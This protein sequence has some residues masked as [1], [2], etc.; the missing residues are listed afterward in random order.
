MEKETIELLKKE[1][2]EAHVADYESPLTF[3]MDYEWDEKRSFTGYACST[4]C[5]VYSKNW[6]MEPLI[7]GEHLSLDER[8]E[9][10][11]VS[12]IMQMAQ[13]QQGLSGRAKPVL[14]TV[15]W[16][17]GGTVF[18]AL[19]V[20]ATEELTAEAIRKA[21][22]TIR[23]IFDV[24]EVELRHSELLGNVK[25]INQMRAY[26]IAL[27]HD[28]PKF[29]SR[30]IGNT[31]HAIQNLVQDHLSYP[32][33][34]SKEFVIESIS[35]LVGQLGVLSSHYE[36][37]LRTLLGITRIARS[38]ELSAVEDFKITD[39][40][41][42]IEIVFYAFAGQIAL[43]VDETFYSYLKFIRLKTDAS[44]LA[45]TWIKGAKSLLIEVVLNLLDNSLKAV[46]SHYNDAKTNP[47]RLDSDRGIVKL[48]M[49]PDSIGKRQFLRITVEDRGVGMSNERL[50]R[51]R[52]LIDTVSAR[53]ATGEY[54]TLSNITTAASILG[55]GRGKYGLALILE[56]LRLLSKGDELKRPE[57]TSQVSEGTTATI[58]FPVWLIEE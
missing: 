5:F 3:V 35:N 9:R 58:W 26:L 51:I 17:I 8:R 54:A 2:L 21:V 48:T 50:N 46:M 19:Q 28:A 32:S 33:K 36:V 42:R 41:N 34:I 22:R 53:A 40:V 47:L 11:V 6:T 52:Q 15:P 14:L 55:G 16:I 12:L 31:V 18:G 49:S 56:I 44:A 25:A 29:L 38:G 24:S 37:F 57:F 27:E 23:G 4:R 10:E 30:P 39:C 1:K 7:R 45:N 13:S 20:N 43:T